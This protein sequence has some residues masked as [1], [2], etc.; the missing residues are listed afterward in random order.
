MN[1]YSQFGQ[2]EWLLNFSDSIGISQGV[3][4][5]AG[6]HTPKKLS[7]SMCFIEAGW[8]AI[9]IES[10]E[11]HCRQWNEMNRGNIEIHCAEIKYNHNGLQQL[12]YDINAPRDID[13]FFF[14]IDGGEY[15]LLNG[16]TEFRPKII[17]VE[18]DNSYPLSIEFIPTQIRHNSQASSRAMYNL[19]T[20][21]GYTY[22]RSFFQDHI[23]IAN[24]VLHEIKACIQ[25]PIGKD[26]FIA[27]AT[28]NLFQFST[29]LLGQVEDQ[30]GSGIDFY[31]SKVANLI[32]HGYIQEAKDYYHLLSLFFHSYGEFA[33]HLRGDVYCQQYNISLKNFDQSYAQY[34]FYS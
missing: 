9:L 18:Y 24:E 4:F 17:C 2:A 20:S 21:K 27:S 31:S 16:L 32:D 15:Q 7:N 22:L 8:R 29:T 1:T 10:D 12:L 13:V 6:A 23:F 33:M 19:M 5:E 34:L 26:A 11:D 25:F 30:G 28:K 14:D 3:V